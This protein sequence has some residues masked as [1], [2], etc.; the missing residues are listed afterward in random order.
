MI[1]LRGSKVTISSKTL[2]FNQKY[3]QKSYTMRIKY[4]SDLNERPTSG[5]LV[6]VEV[7]GTHVVRNP[8]VVHP[9]VTI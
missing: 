4:K 5:S 1:A 2:I 6:W 7:N 3:D 9:E 8:I